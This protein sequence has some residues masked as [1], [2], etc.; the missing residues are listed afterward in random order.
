MSK[1]PTLT[2]RRA[3]FQCQFAHGGSSGVNSGHSH[4][5]IRHASLLRRPHRPYTFT[6]LITLSD[7]SSY[8]SRTTSPAPVYKS[9]KDTRNHPLWQPTLASLRNVEEDEAGRLKAFRDKFGRG[10]DADTTGQEEVV[11]EGEEVVQWEADG[12]DDGDGGSFMDLIT[13]YAQSE[14]PAMRGERGTKKEKK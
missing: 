8:L 7:G 11:K 13:E 5:Q 4:T 3:S 9:T 1:L 2:L 10:W 12:G 6:Q 14:D